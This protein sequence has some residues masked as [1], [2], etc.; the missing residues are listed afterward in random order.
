M[1]HTRGSGATWQGKGALPGKIGAAFEAL[2]PR[3]AAATDYWL[4]ADA[5][6]SVDGFLDP[7][8]GYALLLLAQYGPG[9]GGIVEIGSY[10]GKSTCYLARGS[11]RARREKIT[12][13]DHFLGS[14]EHQRGGANES[15]YV[16]RGDLFAVFT[17]NLAKAEVD[18]WVRPLRMGSAEAAAQWSHPIRLLFIDGDHSYE[19]SR[20]DFEAWGKWL[21]PEGL[22]VFHDIGIFA[23]VTRYYE[24]LLHGGVCTEVLS[25][26]TLRV[27]G[28]T[29]AD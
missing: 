24:E 9:V 28:R 25:V 4:L 13:V 27:A 11:K 10:T 1:G 3:L 23:G 29:G 21:I 20:D 16:V 18:D 26:G 14:P 6:S 19:A 17:E 22:A 15:A 5:F 8:E 7:I 12:A 2:L